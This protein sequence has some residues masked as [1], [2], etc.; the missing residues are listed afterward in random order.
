MN[1][2]CGKYPE[3]TV[4]CSE[5]TK[6]Q[7]LDEKLNFS[8][9]HE[10]PLTFAYPERIWVV[11]DE[12]QLDLGNGLKITAIPTPGHTNGC[13]TW[14]TDDAMFTGD[15]CIS[16]V[17]VVTKLPYGNKREAVQSIEKL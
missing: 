16:G 13:I 11:A 17:K 1:N 12:D 6:L 9:Y 15:A 8:Y 14:M 3:V 7:L 2:L 5:W 4:Y 10:T